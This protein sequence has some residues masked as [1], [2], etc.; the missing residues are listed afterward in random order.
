MTT[1]KNQRLFNLRRK[2]RCFDSVDAE[3][4]GRFVF[5]EKDERMGLRVEKND[6]DGILIWEGIRVVVIWY[7]A[8]FPLIRGNLCCN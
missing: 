4:C 7:F 1:G 3:E 5:G 8:I 2:M 6:I